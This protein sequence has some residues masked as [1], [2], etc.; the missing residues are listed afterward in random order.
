MFLDV[1][2]I[3]LAAWMIFIDKD[4]KSIAMAL[5]MLV[6]WFKDAPFEA[7]RPCIIKQFLKNAK[8]LGI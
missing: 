4:K 8:D 3:A 5:L 2:V 6:L 1:A 7:W